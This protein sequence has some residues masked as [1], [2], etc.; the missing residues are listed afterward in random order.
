[1]EIRKYI[2][3]GTL[4]GTIGFTGTRL[5]V[6]KKADL[7]TLLKAKRILEEYMVKNKDNKNISDVEDINYNSLL[8]GVIKVRAREERLKEL[9]KDKI[10]PINFDNK[11]IE[12]ANNATEE[13]I[14]NDNNDAEVNEEKQSVSE[15]TCVPDNNIVNFD[16]RYNFM[17][18]DYSYDY[19]LVQY[20]IDSNYIT[21]YAGDYY[22]HNT[23]DFLNIFWTLAPG[24]EVIIGNTSYYC[25]GIE[26]AN[27]NE[28]EIVTDNGEVVFDNWTTEIIT[29]NGGYDT[30]YRWVARL[31]LR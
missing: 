18:L 9:T 27:S 24:K 1:M 10:T 19:D 23:S 26:H 6:S 31:A 5:Y 30:P 15:N 28:F 16:E 7:E 20:Y 29:C 25:L 8:E 2:L 12:K 14:S 3:L 21:K 11:T 22:H 4:A 13:V 17:D